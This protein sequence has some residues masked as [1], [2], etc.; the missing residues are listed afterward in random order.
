MIK[1][2]VVTAAIIVR[3]GK[4]LIAR[5]PTGGRH[6]GEWEFPGGKLETGETPRE[7]LAREM[8]EEMG[9]EVSVGEKLASTRYAYADLE[10]E[11]IAFKCVIDEGEIQDYC[12]SAHE[13]V[14]PSKL[15]KYR[16]LPPDRVLAGMI[17]GS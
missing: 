8:F 10:L 11:L 6:P 13:W 5:R 12:C 15:E 2:V 7:C 17:F 1:P 4:V 9:I 3:D 16:L 14:E